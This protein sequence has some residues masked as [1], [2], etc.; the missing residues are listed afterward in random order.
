VRLTLDRPQT[1]LIRRAY[2][3]EEISRLGPYHVQTLRGMILSGE[4][5]ATKVG[6][7]WIVNAAEVARLLGE[8]E[9][10]I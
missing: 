10:R 9:T 7:R 6:K 3:L 8:P 4:L 5:K 1:H 2:D